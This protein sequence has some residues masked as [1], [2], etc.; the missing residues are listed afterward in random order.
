[1]DTMGN[2]AGSAEGGGAE[3]PRDDPRF[4]PYGAGRVSFWMEQVA[5]DLTP[6][7]SLPGDGDVDVAIVGAGFT[8]LWTAYYLAAA[9]PSLRIAVLEREI[10]GFGA[11]G[12]NGGWASALFSAEHDKVAEVGGRAGAMALHRAMVESVDELGRVCAAEGIDAGYQKGG[13]LTV[14]TSEPQRARLRAKVDQARAFGIGEEDLTWL[15]PDEAAERIRAR[16]CVGATY[17]P[18]CAAVQ[19]AALAR[20]LAHAVERRG[21]RVFERTPALSIEPG[22]VRTPYGTLCADVVIRATEGYTRDLPGE[23]RTLAP[24]FSFMVATEPLPDAAWDEIGWANHETLADSPYFFVYAQRTIDGRIAIGGRRARYAFGSRTEAP[25]PARRRSY[26]SVIAA[27]RRLFPAAAGARI[28]HRWYGS[29]GAP[30]DWFSGVDFDPAAR[31]GWAGGYVGDGVT[32]TNLAGRTLTDLILRRDT[33]LVHLP[34]VG[35]RSPRWEPEPLRW[36]GATLGA[37]AMRWA[38]RVEFRTG[39]ASRMGETAM[40]VLG[41]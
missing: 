11:S 20:G 7:P 18:H 30:R 12:R 29:L 9:D 14:A 15:E 10:A 22:S 21:V 2:G 37:L 31:I 6:R 28:T 1:M 5:D 36:T 4:G 38:D 33:D 19:P 41:L 27:M 26:D 34:W 13:T 23:R 40:R 39:R 17:T 25:T 3:D 35:H 32:T 16:G 24:L 8:G